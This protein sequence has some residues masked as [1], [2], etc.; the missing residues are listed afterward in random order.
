MMTTVY[1]LQSD[2]NGRFYIGHTIDLPHRL[3]LH[4]AGLVRATQYLRPWRVVYTE[5]YPSPA[6]A[7]QREWRLKRCK[8][9]RYL[10]SLIIRAGSS[11]GRALHS[12]C[13]GQGFDP[14]P[15]H[16]LISDSG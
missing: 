10:S 2:R 3:V 9:R 6:S 1:I 11:A 5:K 16:Q 14:P 7:R 8:S 4:N 13:R 15:V 12:H